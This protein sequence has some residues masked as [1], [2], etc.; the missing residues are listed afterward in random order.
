MLKIKSLFFDSNRFFIFTLLLTPFIHIENLFDS[1]DLPRFAFVSIVS[2]IW[3][4]SWLTKSNR[5]N[6]NWNPLFLLILTLLFFA[7]TSILWGT[8]NT[9]YQSELYF[10]SS[11]VILIFLFTQVSANSIYSFSV[12]LCAIATIIAIIGILQ[13]FNINPLNYKQIAPPAS[14]FINKNFAANYFDLILPISLTLFFLSRNKKEAWIY[15]ISITLIISYILLMRARGAYIAAIITF[16]TLLISLHLFPLLKKQTKLISQQ[17]KKQIMLIIF[18]PIILFF[19]PNQQYQSDYEENRY[20]ALFSK[21]QQQQNSISVRLNAYQNS[22]DLYKENPIFGVGLGGFQ[23]H[24]R[25]YMQSV[26]A[27]NKIFSDFIYLH[28]EPLQLLIEFGVVGFI[29]V[30]I[31]LIFLFHSVFSLLYNGL[32]LNADPVSSKQKILHLG[33]FIALLASLFHSLFSFPLHQ[34]TPATFFAMYIGILLNLTSKKVFIFQSNISI[35]LSYSKIFMTILLLGLITNFYF[36]NIKSSYYMKEAALAF[37]VNDCEK[38]ASN[39]ILSNNIYGEDY[40]SQS[41]GINIFTSCPLTVNKKLN[42]AEKVL[43]YNPTHPKALFLAGM[44]YYELKNYELSSKIMKS[45]SFLYPYF[46]G[47]YTFLGHIALRKKEFNTAKQFY[48]KALTLAPQNKAARYYF[49]LLI[50]KGY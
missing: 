37:E 24:F 21:Q 14:T 31:F 2:S 28:N 38:A 19:L 7:A 39:A 15:S 35:I 50:K 30:F 10:Y 6:F 12:M 47:S 45:V 26:L 36:N 40:L 29:I 9:L 42:F 22:L 27:K 16:T 1:V 5:K 25:P 11:L 17:Y 44:S 13:N 48:A 34:P 4:L 23:S 8:Q 33:F 20:S 3:L 49:N 43:K 46:T 41:Q 18:I 32:K